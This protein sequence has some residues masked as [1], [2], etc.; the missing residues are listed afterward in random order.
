MKEL[1]GA[2]QAVRALALL[3]AAL[4]AGCSRYPLPEIGAIVEQGAEGETIVLAPAGTVEVAAFA[5]SGPDRAVACLRDATT[6]RFAP[7]TLDLARRT[8]KQEGDPWFDY[9]LGVAADD[10]GRILVI[11][12]ARGAVVMGAGSRGRKMK[13]DELVR[14]AIPDGSG[15]WWL[16]GIFEAGGARH[17]AAHLQRGRITGHAVPAPETAWLGDSGGEFVGLVR[18]D[19]NLLATSMASCGIEGTESPF[20]P[21]ETEDPGLLTACAPDGGPDRRDPDRDWIMKHDLPMQLLDAGDEFVVVLRRRLRSGWTL[22]TFDAGGRRTRRTDLPW[23]WNVR[24]GN[25]SWT[26]IERNDLALPGQPARLALWSTGALLATPEHAG[27]APVADPSTARRIDAM[28][29]THDA[30]LV[31]DGRRCIGDA[32]AETA[33]AGAEGRLGTGQRTLLVLGVPTAEAALKRADSLRR[34]AA[35]APEVLFL[36]EGRLPDGMLAAI[37]VLPAVD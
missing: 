7:W 16:G 30:L 19:G 11:D 12:S 26:V 32:L 17:L 28:P 29:G 31:V 18:R 23:E 34:Q 36:P 13:L 15:G 33:Q 5:M 9:P 35:I 14:A 4:L 20:V 37:A 25:A 6:G 27:A 2:M 8:W 1:P 22:L 10:A 3:M 21:F 24:G